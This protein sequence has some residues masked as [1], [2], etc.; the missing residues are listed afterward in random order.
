MTRVILLYFKASITFS[1][2][3]IFLL[4]SLVLIGKA[5][6]RPQHQS[7]LVNQLTINSANNEKREDQKKIMTLL[8]FFNIIFPFLFPLKELHFALQYFSTFALASLNQIIYIYLWLHIFNNFFLPSTISSKKS[9]SC[10]VIVSTPHLNNPKQR[11]KLST[12]AWISC[13]AS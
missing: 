7:Q 4:F 10:P 3:A 1:S 8:P 9:S 2:F 11:F 5:S 13:C 12:F 6:S